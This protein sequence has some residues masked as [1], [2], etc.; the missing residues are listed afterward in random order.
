MT[1]PV[2]SQRTVPLEELNR[3]G[4]MALDETRLYVGDGPMVYIY[5]L[6]DFKLLKSFGK[7][8]E[9]PQE[10]TVPP[11]FGV[12]VSLHP[13]EEILVVNSRGKI[14]YY[15]KNGRFIREIRTG[16]T[17]NL[18]PFGKRFVGLST[19]A[20]GK[21]LYDTLK[22]VNS[23]FAFF[24]EIARW[25]TPLQDAKKTFF[26]VSESEHS[27]VYG[28]FI[29]VPRSMDFVIDI[30]DT[31]GEKIRTIRLDYQRPEITEAF[32]QRV[33]QWFK[34]DLKYRKYYNEL[35]PMFRFPDKFPAVK[36]FVVSDSKIYVQTYRQREGM[37]EFF[38]LDLNGKLLKTVFL[39]YVDRQGVNIFLLYGIKNGRFYQLVENEKTEKWEVHIMETD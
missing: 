16:I 1:I 22:M 19:V 14:S 9:G 8:G 38:I 28:D 27:Q 7:P 30:F 15:T 37:S 29:Y 21:I 3:P 12:D 39:P 24:K 6:K 36:H 34:T 20:E 32:K 35:K 2:L 33:H 18:K 23:N 4:S 11:G 31:E 13:K 25:K 17:R 10:F 26:L 5:T